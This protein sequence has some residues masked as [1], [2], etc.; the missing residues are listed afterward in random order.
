M[1]TSCISASATTGPSTPAKVQTVT[2]PILN[3]S[4]DPNGAGTVMIQLICILFFELISRKTT[5]S[6]RLRYFVFL[7][8]NNNSII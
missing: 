2:Q 3:A 5:A 1:K 6:R 7:L 4:I 8:Y